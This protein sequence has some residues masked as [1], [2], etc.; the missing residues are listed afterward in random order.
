MPHALLLPNRTYPAGLLPNRTYP[1]GL[2]PNRTYPAGLLPNRTYPAA[3]RLPIRPGTALRFSLLKRDS[4]LLRRLTSCRICVNGQ[5]YETGADYR[6]IGT[7]EKCGAPT[8]TQMLRDR[9][10]RSRFANTRG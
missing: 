7:E 10:Y 2:L 4:Q 5:V 1:A 3:G 8:A 9:S 6:A